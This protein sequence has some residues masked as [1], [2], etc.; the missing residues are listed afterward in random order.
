MY[1]APR[2]LRMSCD[3]NQRLQS[4]DRHGFE[5]KGSSIENKTT[6]QENTGNTMMPTYLTVL[7]MISVSDADE[8]SACILLSSLLELA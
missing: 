4:D 8:T 1:L 7:T 2:L 3:P 6:R 5:F